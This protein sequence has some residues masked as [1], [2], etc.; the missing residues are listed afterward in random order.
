MFDI[1]RTL[2]EILSGIIKPKEVQLP[3][4]GLRTYQNKKIKQNECE[5]TDEQINKIVNDSL[6]EF[7]EKNKGGN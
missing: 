2:K 3:F 5:L 6:K 7:A 4:D 1:I